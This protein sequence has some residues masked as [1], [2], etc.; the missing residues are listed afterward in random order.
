MKSMRY[1][2]PRDGAE[3]KVMQMKDGRWWFA[4]DLRFESEFSVP[5]VGDDKP[6]RLY[7]FMD[8]C[9]ACP[10]GWHLPKY[11]EWTD[12]LKSYG[13]IETFE[14]PGSSD[15]K[16][17]TISK[18]K[19]SGFELPEPDNHYGN[20]C[21]YWVYD[22]RPNIIQRLLGKSNDKPGIIHDRSEGSF[23]VAEFVC[24]TDNVY[25]RAEAISM[26][27]RVRCVRDI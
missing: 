13:P 26:M 4:E 23:Q 16:C 15:L 25:I 18:L 24:F 20:N 10:P 19:G 2:D 9:T 21:R 11:R 22:M 14:W 3:Y 6:A 12:M 8:A 27:Y 7:K 1:T 5:A 17:E